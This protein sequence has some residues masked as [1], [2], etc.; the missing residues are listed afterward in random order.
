MCREVRLSS[1]REEKCIDKKYT[2]SRNKSRIAYRS[3]DSVVYIFFIYNKE[4]G[5]MTQQEKGSHR[6]ADKRH[7]FLTSP[8]FTPIIHQKTLMRH[9]K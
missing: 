7:F 3:N 6:G 8:F 9:K 2:C 5:I 1:A 4:K